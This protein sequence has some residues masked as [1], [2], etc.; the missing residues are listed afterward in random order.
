MRKD[1]LD[2]VYK[3]A[4]KDNRIFFI[5]SDLGYKTL[6]N[7]YEEMPD[8]FLM[9]GINEQNV[10][11]IAAGLALEGKIVYVNTIATFLTRRC[12]EQIVLDLCL[13]N[14]NVRLIGNGGGL[15]YAP[16]GSTHLAFEDL[17]IMRAI[18][19]M[20]I[21]AP[22]DANEMIELMPLTVNHKGPIYI[23]LGKGNEPIVTDNVKSFEIG[24]ATVKREGKDAIIITT[25]VTL[26]TALDASEMLSNQ[27]IETTLLHMSTVKPLDVKTIMEYMN[28]IPVIVTIEEHTLAG[29]LGSAVAEIVAEANFNPA[30][31]FARLGIPDQFPDEYGSQESLMNRYSITAKKLVGTIKDLLNL[32]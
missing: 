3:L 10:I 22:A 12:F 23:R 7:F 5:G 26:H 25:G 20:T 28:K 4:K 32:S 15:V 29:G 9:E 21:L 16:L 17:A 30:K 27:G 24:R 8:R 2:M 1:C 6:N 14:V 11:G 19:N 13:H 31:R 18:P